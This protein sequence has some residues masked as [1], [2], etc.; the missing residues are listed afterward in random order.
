MEPRWLAW[1]K[2][3]QAIAQTGLAYGK[4]IYDVERFEQLRELAV[5]IME[6]HTGADKEAIRLSFASD[7]GYATPKVDIRAVVVQEG[8]VLMVREKTD[9]AWAL[10]GG[11]ADIG[12][13]PFQVAVKEVKEES[14][15]EVQAERLLAVLDKQFHN[16][17]PSPHHIYKM[18]IACSITGGEAASSGTME[19]SEARFFLPEALPELSVERNTAAQ[20]RTMME[21]WATPASPV[22]C[23]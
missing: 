18:F 12:Y 23:D 15:Y 20:I 16:H 5:E 7:T 13:S 6:H 3:I 4:D 8:R 14:G 21:L 17:P 11:W 9:G 22:M 19:T 1:A 2:Q 10:P